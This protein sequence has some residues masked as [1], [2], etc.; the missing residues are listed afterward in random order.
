L[1]LGVGLGHVPGCGEPDTCG[2]AVIDPGETCDL[3]VDNRDEAIAEPGDCTLKCERV[4]LPGCG[5]GLVQN[6]EACDQGDEN[7]P[8][9]FALPGDCTKICELV[10]GCGDG[11]KDEMEACDSGSANKAPEAAKNGECTMDC[12]I[13]ECGDGIVNVGEGCDDG[14]LE[15]MDECSSM[16]LA[17]KCG[18]GVAQ[19]N[20][21]C[22]DGI[23][24][25]NNRSC[26]VD[27]KIA[28][29]GDGLVGPNEE[30]DDGNAVD[31]DGCS[32]DCWSPRTVFVTKSLLEGGLGGLNG[33][34]LQCQMEADGASLGGLYM[35]WLSDA[36]QSPATRFG[37]A[38][39][40]GWYVLPDPSSTKV[41]RGW[42]G[43]TSGGLE[44][45]I[46]VPAD[47]AVGG[48]VDQGVWTNTTPDGQID[49]L[50][51]HCAEWTSKSVDDEGRAGLSKT[52][53][54]DA[55]WTEWIATDCSSPLHLYC[56]QV[57]R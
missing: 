23:N 6:G 14:N 56:F 24:N 13:A 32:D 18:D 48:M 41:A 45:A 55:M 49:D 2:D 26:T 53:Q 12:S 1:A 4:P 17:A 9:E 51:V 52:G 15:D 30:C 5:D 20:E 37:S 16:C 35:A 25:G 21:A 33:A 11:H 40:A 38:S 29:C 47:G 46:V 34:D 8:E 19:V 50:A 22:D 44:G 42:A 28:R 27:C 57:A 31:D 7:R 3:G 43:L 54:M 39:F 10:E 36:T